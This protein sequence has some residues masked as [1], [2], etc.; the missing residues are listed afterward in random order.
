MVFGV[1]LEAS[2]A[3]GACEVPHYRTAWSHQGSQGVL[4]KISLRQQSAGTLCVRKHIRLLDPDA[5]VQEVDSP[6]TTR[7][8]LPFTGTPVCKLA[9]KGRCLLEFDHIEPAFGE[10]PAIAG[11]VTLAASIG[12]NGV[13][14]NLTVL[15]VDAEPPEGKAALVDRAGGNLRTWRFEPAPHTDRLRITY[16]FEPREAAG[17]GTEVRFALPDGVSIAY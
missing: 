2:Y 3:F 15:G 1:L 5:F 17:Q 16:R 9:V 7:I 14:S 10:W 13:V 12:R 11:T 8:D 4:L 6:F